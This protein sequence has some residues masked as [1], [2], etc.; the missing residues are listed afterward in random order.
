MPGFD[1]LFK[2]EGRNLLCPESSVLESRTQNIKSGF[3]NT[4]R[5][6]VLKMYKYIFNLE[7][8]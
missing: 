3:I 7:E 8:L 1:G 4:F 5:L 6:R 2:T